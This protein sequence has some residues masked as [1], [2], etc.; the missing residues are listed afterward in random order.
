MTNEFY[1]KPVA[2]SDFQKHCAQRRKYPVLLQI[3]Y[4]NA[5]KERDI[6]PNTTCRVGGKRSNQERNQNPRIIPCND[7]IT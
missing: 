2:V 4:N 5:V 7:Q 3:E 1:E 6:H